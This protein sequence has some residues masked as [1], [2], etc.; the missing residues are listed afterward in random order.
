[1]K[2]FH[3]PR[4]TYAVR[5]QTRHLLLRQQG[6]RIM[7]LSTPSRFS[8][9]C[10]WGL[11]LSMFFPGALRADDIVLGMSAAFKGPSRGLSIELYRGSIAYFEHINRSGGVHGK[12]IRIKAYDDGYNPKDA[13]DNT[14]RLVEKDDVFLLFDYM[15]TPTV[16]RILPL[17]KKH[18]KH[19]V[20][21]FFP[22]TGAEPHRQ[23]PYDQFV[24]N[25]RASYHKE[26]ANLVNHFV[27]IGRKKIAVFYQIDAYGRNGWDGV[28]KQLAKNGLEIVAEATYPRGTRYSDSL[29]QQVAILRKADPNAI[30]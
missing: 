3:W 28:R 29:V 25:L 10:G 11:L 14:M 30:V 12:S 15:G 9:V 23:Y 16:T 19:S 13:V 8:Q 2:W 21:L 24:F 18:E 26:T 4:G 22:F 5:R 7:T 17:L 6:N 27:R 20:Y 1:M